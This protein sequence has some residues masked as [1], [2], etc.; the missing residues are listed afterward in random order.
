MAGSKGFM[1]QQAVLSMSEKIQIDASEFLNAVYEDMTQINDILTLKDPTLLIE[2]VTLLY[3]G[4]PL[5]SSLEHNRY[6]SNLLRIANMH[7]LFERT[8]SSEESV[9]DYF[10]LKP[11]SKKMY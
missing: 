10:Y 6:L 11:K 2:G 9:I 1:G 7:D 5:A 3:N 4:F 8:S